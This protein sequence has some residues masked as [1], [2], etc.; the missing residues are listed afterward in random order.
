[1]KLVF[2]PYPIVGL[3]I[4]IYLNTSVL[5][6]QEIT[7][8]KFIPEYPT[9]TDEIQLVVHTS[10]PFSNCRLDSV[11]PYFACGAFSW[12]A[13]YNTD[14]DPDSCDRSDTLSLGTLSNGMWVVSFRM[15][16]LGWSQV[17]QLDTSIIVGTTGLSDNALQGTDDLMN[18]WP[19][20]STGIVN[21]RAKNSDV[22]RILI[23]GL[24]GTYHKEIDVR[25]QNGIKQNTVSLHAGIYICTAIAKD[26]TISV[27]K[28]IVL[29]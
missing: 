12:D 11:H 10:F 8:F 7:S 17:D 3:I 27:S 18:I 5:F 23:K 14:F 21:I 29:E 24:S 19:N 16:Y 1:M 20:P 4:F 6:G 2:T 13:F 22:D 26:R 28:L 9:N 15:H 25:A